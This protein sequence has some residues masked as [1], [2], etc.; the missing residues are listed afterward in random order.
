M[1]YSPPCSTPT[2]QLAVKGDLYRQ[3]TAGDAASLDVATIVAMADGGHPPADHALRDYVHAHIDDDRFGELPVQVRAYAQRALKR[4][5]LPLG[6]PSNCSQVVNDF[7]R[8]IAVPVLVDHVV[9]CWPHVPKL[10]SS[11]NR[12][13]AAWFVGLPFKLT[14]RQI[15]RIYSARHTLARRLAEFMLT[16]QPFGGTP[17]GRQT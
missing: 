15:R 17:F 9:H 13:S 1:D 3:L 6:Y 2:P 7:T 10:Y 11:A 16:T 5:P 8:D 12:H 4:P 14:E